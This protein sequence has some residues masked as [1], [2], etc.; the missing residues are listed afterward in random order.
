[1]ADSRSEIKRGEFEPFE[2]LAQIHPC[3]SIAYK[4]VLVAAGMADMRLS[5][6]AL[7]MSGT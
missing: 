1:M 7:R 4:L 5:A 2:S 3:G 6:S